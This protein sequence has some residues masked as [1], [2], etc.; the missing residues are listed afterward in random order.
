MLKHFTR[1]LTFFH[2]RRRDLRYAIFPPPVVIKKMYD[3]S[4]NGDT[5]RINKIMNQETF[6]NGVIKRNITLS[7]NGY[8]ESFENARISSATGGYWV[9]AKKFY[10][11]LDVNEKKVFFSIIRQIHIDVIADFFALL[12]GVYW[13]EGQ[14]ED[15]RLVCLDNPEER[16]NDDL[17]TIFLNLIEDSDKKA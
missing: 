8:M 11:S 5:G 10:E 9:D 15:L 4:F 1:K 17:T 3:V 12:D 2:V 14:E 16:L 6:I 13:L 7:L